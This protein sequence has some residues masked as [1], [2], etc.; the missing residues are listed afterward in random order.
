[1]IEE[2]KNI[3]RKVYGYEDFL[4]LQEKIIHNVLLQKNTLALLPTGGGKSLCY[5]IPGLQMDGICIVVSPLVALIKDQVARLKKQ[6][7]KAMGITGAVRYNDLDDMLDNAVYG[8]YKFLYLSPERLQQSLV[9]ERLTKM[10]INLIAV[11]EAHCISEW[12][13]DFRPAYRDIALLKKLV[14]DAPI[15][16]LT[17]TATQKVQSDILQNLGIKEANVFKNS[18]KRDNIAYRIL[19]TPDK[20]KAIIQFYKS[21]PESSIAYVRSRKNSIEFAHLLEHNNIKAAF[22]HGGLNHKLRDHAMKQWMS[23]QTTVMVATNAFG[24]GIDKPDVRSIV[25][26]QLPD[27]IESYFQETG[28]AGRDGNSSVAQF[29]YNINDLNHA[30]NQFIKGLPTVTLLKTVYRKLNSYLQIPKGEGSETSHFIS[31][32]DFCRA[33]GFNGITSYN[34]LMALDRFGVIS[35]LQDI[36]GRTSLR[37]RESG[38]TILNFTKNDLVASSILQALMRTYGSSQNQ[39]LSINLGLIA[40]RSN[41]TEKKVIEII[42][43]MVKLK[44]VEAQ[45]STADT[46]ITFL[47]PRE[48]DRT[49]NKFSKALESQ[50]KLKES[51]LNAMMQLVQNK[52]ECIQ[53]FIL[54]YFDEPKQAPCGKCSICNPKQPKVINLDEILLLQQLRNPLGFEEIHS[55][56]DAD[57]TQLTKVLRNLLERHKIYITNDNKYHIN[58]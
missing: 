44:L 38:K 56:F 12:G 8:N 15:I 9:Q 42:E 28:R 10:K 30:H 2:A 46:Q 7:V 23:N 53:N 49:I 43:K 27:S 6:N 20:R 41:T 51:K 47:V 13:H 14:P 16:A 55:F 3:L 18:F 19:D 29:I 54:D 1:M 11:D 39:D 17:A 5:Q 34:A 40:L 33:Y 36:K 4:P 37:F 45:L 48:D 25:H 58:E 35:M 24:M 26:L 21:K 31:F 32:S 57:K 50:N 52:D 22:Y